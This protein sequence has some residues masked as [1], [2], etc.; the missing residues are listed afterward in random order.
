VKFITFIQSSYDGIVT[1]L[2]IFRFIYQ[3]NIIKKIVRNTA[4]YWL[5][6]L[7]TLPVG[8]DLFFDIK[9]RIKY[10]T[11][12]IL[13]D[14]GANIGQTRNWFRF[15]LPN[16]KIVCFEPVKSTFEQLLKN[17]ENDKNT[18]VEKLALGESKFEKP[19][20]LYEES[21]GTL[22]SLNEG[23]MNNSIGALTEVISVDTLDQYCLDKGFTKIDLLKMD[24][25]GYDINVL[26]G[27]EQM[28]KNGAISMIYCETGFQFSNTRNTSF[29]EL[30]QFLE[31]NDYYFFG[32][33]QVD[34]WDWKNGNNYGN[35]LYVHKSVF[36]G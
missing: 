33:Y 15:H 3:M 20:R 10:P 31:N 7:S 14:V 17:S 12:N 36:Q 9:E 35:A 6:K 22:N 26:K 23:S 24:T 5:H 4:G 34:Y 1:Q 30:T 25:E 11:L 13:F 32:L 2:F 28:M 19:I 8:A 18:I 27:A 21:L 16:S 29:F